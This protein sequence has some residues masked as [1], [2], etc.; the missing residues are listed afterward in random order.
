[1][2][3]FRWTKTREKAA[4][5]LAAGATREAAAKAAGV[6]TST[7]Y[8]WLNVAEFAE[9]VDRLTFMVGIAQRADRL[10]LAKR[11]VAK[12]AEHTERDLLDWLKYVQG[13]TDGVKLDLTQLYHA[14]T[15]DD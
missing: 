4:L 15:T 14:V 8:A 10:R 5:E 2:K 1:M 9:E 7:I 3:N 11:V 6:G 13:E 12:L